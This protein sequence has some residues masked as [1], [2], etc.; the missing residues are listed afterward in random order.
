MGVAADACQ[1]NHTGQLRLCPDLVSC[2]CVV[3]LSRQLSYNV[4]ETFLRRKLLKQ[5]EATDNNDDINSITEGQKAIDLCANST[6]RSVR[7]L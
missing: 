4:T 6:I 3:L 1:V 5:I 7:Q 2:V